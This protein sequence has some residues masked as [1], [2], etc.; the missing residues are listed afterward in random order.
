MRL[1]A[2]VFAFVALPCAISAQT[3]ERTYWVLSLQGD[4]LCGNVKEAAFKSIVDTNPPLESARITYAANKLSEVTYQTNA[5]SGDW[6]VIDKYTLSDTVTHLRRAIVFIGQRVE[7]FQDATIRHG[8][9][10]PFRIV[11]VAPTDP[12]Q[13][14]DTVDLDYPSVTV[15]TDLHASPY[16]EIAEEMRS[17]SR[18]RLCRPGKADSAGSGSEPRR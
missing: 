11:K 2:S 16:V 7:V 8:K 4:T 18:T 3:A 6:I 1:M 13:P 9:A 15:V 14:P 17:R 10:S 12:K 5:E